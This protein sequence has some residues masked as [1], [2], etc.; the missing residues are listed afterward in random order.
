MGCASSAGLPRDPHQPAPAPPP[1]PYIPPGNNPQPAS[2]QGAQQRPPP[3]GGGT[4]TTAPMVRSLVSL[5]RDS[6]HVQEESGQWFLNFE[7]GSLA[8]G[9]ATASFLATREEVV[10]GALTA[11][12]ASSSASLRFGAETRQSGR[13]FLSATL[14]ESLKDFDGHHVVLD[15][16]ADSEDPASVTLQRS[17]LRLSPEGAGEV[18]VEKQLVQCGS[19]VRP[20]DALYGTMPNP[21]SS[22][23]DK[24]EGGDCVICLSNP[25]EVAILHCRHVCLC[26]TCAKVTSSTWSFQC[27]V[28]R[29]RVAAMVGLKEMVLR[30]ED[31]P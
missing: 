13:L 28:C 4:L 11:P 26:S 18:H 6:C 24:D 14:P 7:F 30:E 17:I 22:K 19:I 29:G 27:P 8:T 23:A 12:S 10:G 20:L 5:R 15:L 21:R 31:V 16:R 2:Q 25:R 1:P 3:D 9:T